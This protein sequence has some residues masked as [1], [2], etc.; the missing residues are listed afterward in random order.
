[1]RRVFLLFFIALGFQKAGSQCQISEHKPRSI[2]ADKAV[3]LNPRLN[4]ISGLSFLDTMFYAIID[5]GNHAGN[6]IFSF[7]ESGVITDSIMIPAP[8]ID[9][10]ELY[11]DQNQFCIGDIGNNNGT[12]NQLQF[13]QFN[14]AHKADSVTKM[15]IIKT[16]L[17]VQN[18]HTGF[19]TNRDFEAFLVLHSR[20]YLFSKSKR[21]RKCEIYIIHCDSGNGNMKSTNQKTKLKF[22]VTGSCHI[23]MSNQN[24]Q[25]LLV[26]YFPGIFRKLR[27]WMAMAEIDQKQNQ[28]KLLW[29]KGISGIRN[30]QIESVTFDHL[31]H[32]W[33]ASE[34]TKKNG[35]MIYR[36]SGTK[37]KCQGS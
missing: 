16:D 37:R 8:N 26:G 15:N 19:F 20:I 5:G 21:N 35:P 18:K 27:P 9:W 32:I 36:I 4:E 2:R 7:N 3:I 1:M 30:S 33:V 13:Y 11:I 6:K 24:A 10:E 14:R 17:T 28:F 22:W 31:G 25:I 29:Q 34:A 23:G 12:R